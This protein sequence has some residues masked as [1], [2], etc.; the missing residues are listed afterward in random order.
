M[1]A[2]TV[3]RAW[4]LGTLLM[5]VL[6]AGTLAGQGEATVSTQGFYMGS[7]GQPSID[8][9]GLALHFQ[10]FIPNVGL[11]DSKLENYEGSGLWEHGDNY[12][13]LRGLVWSDTRWTLR[14]G[15]CRVPTTLTAFPFSN[16]LNPDLTLRGE[17]IGARRGHFSYS[18]FSGDEVLQSGPRIPFWQ[19]TPQT[20]SGASAK[21]QLGNLELAVRYIR[22]NNRVDQLEQNSF[23]FP[24]NRQFSQ[25]GVFTGKLS[26]KYKEHV[27][28]YAEEDFSQAKFLEQDTP[29][30]KHP[31]S[32]L[33]GAAFD[34]QRL[35]VRA[36]YSDQGV[37]TLPVVGYFAG[38]RRGPFADLRLRP[39][40]W[41]EI[42][43]SAARQ[44]NNLEHESAVPTLTSASLMAG[45]SLH[46]PFRITTSVQLSDLDLKVNTVA[47]N[48][49][50]SSDNLMTTATL[51]RPFT[52]HNLNLTLREI[53]V[54]SNG[55]F[56]IQTSREAEDTMHW[57]NFVVGG[58]IRFDTDLSNQRR[59]TLYGRGN[60]QVHL[61]KLTAYSYFEI[62][63]DLVNQS[64]FTTSAI[65]TSVLGLSSQLPGGL[66]F[67]AEAFRSNLTTAP[68]ATNVFL[69]ATQGSAFP[70]VLTGLNQWSLY[71]RMTRQFNW[72]R[73]RGQGDLDRYT[74]EQ[75]PIVGNVEG[76]VRTQ[77]RGG[78]LPAN[79]IAVSVDDARFS[80]TD[81]T[82]HY[83]IA[84]VPEGYHAVRLALD[85]LPSDLE[86]GPTQPDQYTIVRG[87][88]TT[89]EDFLVYPLTG[90]CGNVEGPPGIDL[91]NVVLRIMPSERYTTP[92][93]DGGFCFYNIR[94]DDYDV[95]LDASTL[96]AQ[97]RP[98][99]PVTAPFALKLTPDAQPMPVV[100]RLG[101]IVEEKPI[102]KVLEGKVIQIAPERPKPIAPAVASVV[103]PPA[104]KSDPDKRTP[105]YPGGVIRSAVNPDSVQPSA[106]PAPVAP[107]S[108]EASA[109]AIAPSA[110][111]PKPSLRARDAQRE[112]AQEAE[113]H[114]ARGR[115]LTAQTKFTQAIAELTVA[116][117]LKPDFAQAYNARG[118]AYLKARRPA[119][120]LRD[121][122]RAISLKPNYLNAYQNRASARKL[123][124]DSNGAAE[125][126]AKARELS[127]K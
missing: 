62:G 61:K 60:A 25:A 42:F 74:V 41:L 51:T 83:R 56:D 36:N 2:V 93:T 48:Q 96:P 30:E 33:F 26:Y 64:V 29:T 91:E 67:Q 19:S 101:A 82:G 52:H 9:T 37:L 69:L 13:E 100:F 88:Q 68:N 4:R 43:G 117:K 73:E 98:L 6:G 16:Y 79:G 103:A 54:N 53:K 106:P 34:S 119:E 31:W 78:V 20:I 84:N 111:R 94:E 85:K 102:R 110:A 3:R 89:R 24:A 44:S 90:F 59:N 66:E 126:A 80:V 15:N 77:T 107:P 116:I 92:D 32:S 81:E 105:V 63:Q 123:A 122:D 76:I 23:L 7:T 124:G 27:R 35:S 125:D 72:G 1:R 40:H 75:I 86:P 18:L 38:D 5:W 55:K 49:Q 45:A 50:T 113:L 28:L 57:G 114:N 8:A 11:L 118:F 108:A 99:S 71:V 39:S 14:Y 12:L 22:L 109:A 17:C 21:Y 46:L 95:E 65:R 70:G 127:A 121:L 112:K 104:A 87:G 47:T 115:K 120:A 58:A 10:Q 97:V